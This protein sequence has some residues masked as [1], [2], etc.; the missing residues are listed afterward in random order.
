ML[1]NKFPYTV[2]CSLYPSLTIELW[3]NTMHKNCPKNEGKLRNRNEFV[4]GETRKESRLGKR[5]LVF[6]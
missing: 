5:E 2:R 6:K 1:N 4:V 3:Q